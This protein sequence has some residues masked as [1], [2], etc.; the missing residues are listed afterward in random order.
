MTHA[1]N[2]NAPQRTVHVDARLCEGHALCIDLAPEVFDL[3]D[4]EVATC[5]ESPPEPLWDKVQAAVNTCP[6]QA[7]GFV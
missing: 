2:H 7:I 6:R 3:G 1:T 5:D 4:D